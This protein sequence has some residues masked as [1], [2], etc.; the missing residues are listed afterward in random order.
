MA[1]KKRGLLKG[2]APGFGAY[3]RGPALLKKY[4][5]WRWLW[6]PALL[7]LTLSVA[8]VVGLF[9]GFDNFHDWLDAKVVLETVWLDKLISWSVATLS[10][11]AA[12]A[13]F[14][15]LQKHLVLVLLAPF[16]GLLAEV[17]VRKI[18][19]DSFEQRLR[20][21]DSIVRSA[22]VN[23]RSIFLEILAVVAFFFVG[24][25]IPVIGSLVS[26]VAVLLIQNCFLG[27]GLLDFPLEYRGRSVKESILFCRRH[28]GEATGL[29][30]GYFLTMLVPVLGWMLAPML[31]T[32]AGTAL[33]MDLM[34]GEGKG[35]GAEEIEKK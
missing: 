19:G 9:V 20:P 7:S 15:F 30:L 25:V 27:N 16:L 33:A 29:G 22:K 26:S 5:L 4:Q 10:V 6:I 17:T 1:G 14:V 34:E 31:G 8:M 35:K 23:T 11:I 3:L 32:V 28:R 2:L 24:L 13:A 21:I 18:E 12:V